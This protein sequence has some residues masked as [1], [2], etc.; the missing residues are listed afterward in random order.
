MFDRGGVAMM[1]V[2]QAEATEGQPVPDMEWTAKSTMA[3]GECDQRLVVTSEGRIERKATGKAILVGVL[4]ALFGLGGAVLG[5]V[6]MRQHS[7]A[8]GLFVLA[9]NSLFFFLGVFLIR[10][11]REPAI[12]DRS[13]GRFVGGRGARFTDV[14]LARIRALQILAKRIEYST[15]QGR[16]SY[17]ARELNLVLDDGTRANLLCHGDESVLRDDAA[18]LAGFLGVQIVDGHERKRGA[19]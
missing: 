4:F 17:I 15:K 19:G 13:A 12:F 11:E 16:G 7:P 14:A 2:E 3:S 5:V 1:T 10:R 18:R 8:G 6:L 9:I